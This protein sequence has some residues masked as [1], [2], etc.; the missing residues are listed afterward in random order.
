[1]RECGRAG[2][3]VILPTEPAAQTEESSVRLVD[4]EDGVKLTAE[5]YMRLVVDIAKM[6]LAL[7]VSLAAYQAVRQGWHLLEDMKIAMDVERPTRTR[8]DLEEL[9]VIGN[10]FSVACDATDFD[11]H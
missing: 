7:S 9:L 1:M 8:S 11:S 3:G 5:D 6:T 10:A 4:S 2:Y